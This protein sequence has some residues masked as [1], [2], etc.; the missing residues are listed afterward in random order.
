M[1]SSISSELETPNNT[2]CLRYLNVAYGTHKRQKMD[3]YIPITAEKKNYPVVISLHGGNW[4]SGDKQ[5]MALYTQTIL[6]SECIHVAM[7]YRLIGDGLAFNAF[8]PFTD[9]L[10]DIETVLNFLKTNAETY[11]VDTTKAC[12]TG[13]SAGG[14]LALLYA[15]S[16][17]NSSIPITLAF[18]ISAPTDFLDSNN[19]SSTEEWVH[20]AHNGHEEI[21]VT[22]TFEKDIRVVT[23]SLVSGVPYESD[24]WEEAWQTISPVSY[25][26]SDSPKTVLIHGTHDPII[27]ISQ[28]ITLEEKH[29]YCTLHEI[30]NGGHEAYLAVNT[31]KTI[32]AI[33]ADSLSNF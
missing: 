9:M 14:H 4:V 33:L 27:P 29:P 12:M 20:E 21:K 10:N 13:Y 26:Q 3:I 25:L 18:T 15:Y 5:Q 7:N 32:N 30:Y 16:R 22:P 8:M 1:D 28:A 23:F 17:T 19:F 2:P 11:S 24:G 6:E 31:N